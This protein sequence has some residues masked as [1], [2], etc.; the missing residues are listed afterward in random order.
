M[1]LTVAITTFDRIQYLRESFEQV[2]DHPRITEI[3][4]MDDCSDLEIFKQVEALKALSP[5]FK[6]YRQAKN[7]GMGYNKYS[8][9]AHASNDWVILFDSDNVLTPSYVDAIPKELSEKAIYQPAFA[10]PHFDFRQYA[11]K[12]YPTFSTVNVFIKQPM[13]FTMVNACNYVVNRNEYLRVYQEN[14]EHRASDTVWMFYLW[15]KAGNDL[16]VV[17]GMEYEHRVHDQSGFLQD[18]A[19]NLKKAEEVRKLIMAL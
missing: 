6:V 19:Y 1:N 8:A 9:V 5:K 3:I 11:G 18:A 2:I 10:K 12:S 13:F 14:P 7:R 15:L 17:P 16:Y 4:L